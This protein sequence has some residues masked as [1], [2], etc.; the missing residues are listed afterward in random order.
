MDRTTVVILLLAMSWAGLQFG[1]LWIMQT[2]ILP[3]MNSRGPKEYLDTCQGI[4]MHLFHRIAL[5]GGIVVMGLGIYLI[6]KGFRPSPTPAGIDGGPV[7]RGEG[8]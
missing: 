6:V 1:T 8:S 7:A 5:T 4:N 3:L 2:S